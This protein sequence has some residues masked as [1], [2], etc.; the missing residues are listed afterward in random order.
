M[1]WNWVWKGFEIHDRYYSK[2]YMER[3]KTSNRHHNSNNK[4]NNKVGWLTLP[5]IK[6]YYK[7]TVIQTLILAKNRLLDQWKIIESPK[8]DPCKYILLISDYDRNT[9]QWRKSSI[10]IKWRI[11]KLDIQMKKN[12]NLDN[13]FT[14]LIKLTQ[15][16]S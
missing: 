12:V 2:V 16:G 13:E 1:I 8:I 11:G 10:F 15:N 5:D 4:K 7:A 9:I 14:N 3:Q 6:I